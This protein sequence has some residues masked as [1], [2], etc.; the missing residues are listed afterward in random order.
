MLV[1][2]GGLCQPFVLHIQGP[3]DVD[4]GFGCSQVFVINFLFFLHLSRFSFR[5]YLEYLFTVL[6]FL[7]VFFCIFLFLFGYYVW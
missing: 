5:S 1:V 6:S 2:I 7:L 3:R 4:V